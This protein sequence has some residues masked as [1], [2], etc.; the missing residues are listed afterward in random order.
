MNAERTSNLANEF[1]FLEQALSEDLL[2]SV[3]VFR[4]AEAN[5]AL[6]AHRH[7]PR[8]CKWGAGGAGKI[9][10]LRPG[11]LPFPYLP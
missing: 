7:S 2:F 11:L 9:G 6:F 10:W 1:T 5:A 8:Q 4:S 3:H